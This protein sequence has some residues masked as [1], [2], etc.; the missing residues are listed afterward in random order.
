MIKGVIWDVDGTLLDSMS[1]WDDV[2]ARYLKSID[3]EPEP[4]LGDV[5]FAMSLE[6]GADYMKSHYNL[7]ESCEQIIDGVL[8][9]IGDFYKYEVQLKPGMARILDEYR[10]RDILMT[11]A[12]TSD[13]ELVNAAFKR[14]GIA[15]YFSRIFTATELHTTKKEP[16]IYQ[17]AAKFMGCEPNETIVYEDVLHAIR[18]AKNAEFQTIA[19]YDEASAHDWKKIS[20]IADSTIDF[21]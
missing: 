6:E 20:E 17:T 16:L 10:D 5:L 18:T 19:V 4:G 14:L 12:T 11:V 9:V 15:D 3:I 1:I 2:G 21:K 7:R 13:E 8:G